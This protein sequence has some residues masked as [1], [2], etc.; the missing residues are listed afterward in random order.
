MVA[1][2]SFH[3]GAT[4]ETIKKVVE[5]HY[6]DKAEQEEAAKAAAKKAALQRAH[7]QPRPAPKPLKP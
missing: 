1:S 2:L 6:A 4:L 3:I 7:L 5:N